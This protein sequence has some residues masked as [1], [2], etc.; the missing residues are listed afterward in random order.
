MARS[1]SAIFWPMID[2]STGAQVPFHPMYL[3]LAIGFAAF[4]VSW[5]NDSGFWV[6]TRLSG[7]TEKE[8]LKSFTVLLTVI[9]LF[10]GICTLIGSVVFPM[11]P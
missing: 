6:V 4:T 7:M 1:A 2:P 10:G 8:S 11:K 9:S 5:M 3:Y